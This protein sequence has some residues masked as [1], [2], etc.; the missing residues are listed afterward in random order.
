MTTSTESRK[1][2]LST[3]FLITGG[4]G[5]IFTEPVGKLKVRPQAQSR[6]S[7]GIFSESK[8]PK[9][10]S[11]EIH[12]DAAPDDSVVTEVVSLESRKQYELVLYV[13]NYGSKTIDVDVWRI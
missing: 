13:S 12:P 10:F 2:Q 1:K 7:L 11:V 5:H 4:S 6:M 3:G 9:G 8:P